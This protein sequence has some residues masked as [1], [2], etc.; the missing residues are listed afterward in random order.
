MMP[1]LGPW[2]CANGLLVLGAAGIVFVLWCVPY[3]PTHDGP[4][5]LANCVL[6]DHIDQKFGGA[7]RFLERGHPI[8]N[9]G[10]Q[11]V[12][13][14]LNRWFGWR[15]A[16]RLTLTL[17]CLTF[18]LGYAFL[19]RGF[20]GPLSIELFGVIMAF[21]WMFYM[22]F[23]NFYFGLGLGLWLLG[24]L[25]RRRDLRVYDWGL[26][27]GAL[28]VLAVVHVFAAFLIGLVSALMLVVRASYGTRFRT[29]VR[30]ALAGAPAGAVAVFTSQTSDAPVANAAHSSA[31]RFFDFADTFQGGSPLRAWGPIVFALLCLIGATGKRP[32]DRSERFVFLLVGW[33]SVFAFFISPLHLNQW[34]YFSPR[35]HF[36]GLLLAP[37]ALPPV[38]TRRLQRGLPWLLTALAIVALG[39]S[40]RH[41]RWLDL[42]VSPALAGIDAPLLRRGARLP[43]TFIR[44]PANDMAH[45]DPLVMS[46]HLYMFSQGGVD[47]YLWA[48]FPSLDA[49]VYKKPANE[50]FGDHMG[51]FPGES[52]RCGTE[53]PR[54]P[55]CLDVSRQYELFVW[56]ARRFEDAIVFHDDP[57]FLSRFR[58][59]G[60][61]V[62]FEQ[63][64]LSIVRPQTCTLVVRVSG[65]SGQ[66]GTAPRAAFQ[67]GWEGLSGAE[68]RFVSGPDIGVPYLTGPN[69]GPMWLE[70][71]T[72]GVRCLE[73]NADG[74]V[75]FSATSASP[76]VVTCSLAAKH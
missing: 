63:G 72:E 73:S 30:V 75:R 45:A 13:E 21:P 46:G 56:I 18:A 40:Y 5:H 8:T 54:K 39:W 1:R 33:A 23:V 27:A 37:L 62:D 66:D 43:Y 34:A 69:C 4:N 2:I 20:A 65:A 14:P 32:F 70:T 67:V 50:L 10:F 52:L 11:T 9:L 74:R 36:L 3:V 55:D 26:F 76:V 60:F 16:Y 58:E 41:H 49:I 61:A 15:A 59:R 28:A 53:V 25:V 7:D 19:A 64:H 71:T 6:A 12:C 57:A 22:G 47:P 44:T 38:A 24:A 42:Q 35:L 68:Y 31:Q 29:V 48:G 17:M 51:R